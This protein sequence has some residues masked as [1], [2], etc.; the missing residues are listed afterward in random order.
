MSVW[1]IKAENFRV[2]K[3]LEWS[4]QGVCLLAG[5]NGS[6]KTTLLDLLQFLRVLFSQGHEAALSVVG[7]SHIRSLDSDAQTPVVFE[8]EV[9]DI[10]WRLRFPMSE[11]G[12]KGSYGEELLFQGKMMLRAALFGEFWFMGAERMSFDE[13]RCCARVLWDRGSAE[14]MKPLVE[15]L[16]GIRV[17]QN[18]LYHRVKQPEAVESSSSVLHGSGKNLWSVLSNWK[19]SP[20]RYADAFDWVLRQTQ[21]AMPGLL[22]SIE[23]DRGLTFLYGPRSTDPADG[24]PPIRMPDGL[25]TTLLHLTAIA[26]ASPGGILAFDELENQLH[27]HAIRAILAAMRERAEARDLTII[28]TSHSPVV[29]NAFRH[30]P[31][32]FYVMEQGQSSVPV[33]LTSLHDEDWLSAFSLGDLYDRLEVASPLALQEA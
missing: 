12:L 16:N 28:L 13:V 27:P 15:L 7:G 23:F 30:Q 18:Y 2:L 19:S 8:L 24:L 11:Q 5:A 1:R 9:G 29:M 32:Q 4:P 20:R 26:G 25:L 33:P 6:G 14:W 22:Q 31:E 17:Y 10:V 21:K 3:A